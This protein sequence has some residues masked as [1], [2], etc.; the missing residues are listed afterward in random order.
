MLK[1]YMYILILLTS[2]A[3]QA[4]GTR[5]TVTKIVDGDTIHVNSNGTIL[6][7][8]LIGIDAPEKVT[9]SKVR[10]DSNRTGDDI[11]TILAQ[12]KRST[13]YLKSILR[14]GASVTLEYDL[15]Q[16][17]RNG[18]TLAYVYLSDGRMLNEL[19]I[20]AGYAVPL[21]VPPNVKYR[22]RFYRAHREA[23]AAKRGLWRD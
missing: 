14:K 22:D 10:R 3:A 21:T 16:Y 11:R 19:I 23:K 5:A 8:R 12:G 1:R 17:D 7:V 6:K 15:Q 13:N 20:A 4:A 9:N 18:R 2:V